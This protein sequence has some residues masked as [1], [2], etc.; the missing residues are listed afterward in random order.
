GQ[1]KGVSSD[2]ISGPYVGGVVYT[3]HRDG[4]ADDQLLPAAAGGTVATDWTD[5]MVQSPS[6]GPVCAQS[7]PIGLRWVSSSPNGTAGQGAW[8]GTPSRLAYFA[9]EITGVDST[10]T[11]LNPASST[12]AAILDAALRWLVSTSPTG[13]DRDHPDVNITSP[14]GGVFQG[15]SIPITWTASAHGTGVVLSTF[16]AT[17]DDR[18]RG[19]SRIA[20]AELFLRT[21]PPTA[22]DAGTGIPMSAS[23]GSF[24]GTVESIGWEGALAAPPGVM[25]SWI[26]AE[27]MASN[28]GPY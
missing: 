13:L 27:D 1:A 15:P 28:W 9:F 5:N 11:N 26:H 10:A 12:R 2:P 3:P 8:N 18:S 17:A 7:Q 16:N 14:T 4:G 20:A 24:D 25:C 19:G 22:G 23:D 6:G 21:T